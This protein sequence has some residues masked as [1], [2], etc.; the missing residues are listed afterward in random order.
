MKLS[1]AIILIFFS[2]YSFS[3]VGV[4]TTDPKS[5]LHIEAS[6]ITTPN[7]TDGILI[8]RIDNFPVT[9]PT[10]DQNGMLVFLNTATVPSSPFGV[11]PI[12]FYYWS[13]P[14]ATWV[15]MTNNSNWSLT[16]NSGTIDGTHYLGTN[17]DVPLNFK[18]NSQKAGRIYARQTFFGYLS[19]NVNTGNDNT[20][21]GDEALRDNTTG[22]Q[23]TV[24]GSQAMRFNTIGKENT[25]VGRQ[26]LR[27]NTEGDENTAVGRHALIS[28]TLGDQNT[29]IGKN[30]MVSNTQG[31]ENTALGR[32]AL[33]SN[34]LGNENTAVGRNA[35][36]SSTI[37]DQN[38]AVGKNALI[39]NTDGDQNTAIGRHALNDNTTGFNNSAVGSNALPHN[40][41][42]KEN[43]AIGK[44]ALRDNNIG[45]KNTAIGTES[46]INNESGNQ[47]VGVGFAAMFVNVTGNENVAIGYD[48]LRDN[49]SGSNNTA[50]GKNALNSN[51]TGIRNTAIGYNSD[52]VSSGLENATAI[53]YDAIVNA[54]NKVR[55]GNTAVTVVE[56]QVALTTTSDSR[57]KDDINDIPLGL[58]FIN[59][60]RPV[61]YTRKNN[62]SKQK[63]WGIIAQE[64]K[65]A[66]DELNYENA[67]I[68]SEDNSENHYLSVRYTDLIS[69]II[70]AIQELSLKEKEIE[71]LKNKI[72]SQDV[73][74]KSLLERIEKLEK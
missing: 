20:A 56:A 23:N 54:S 58:N 40:T 35:L 45:E 26:A 55:I 60:L 46:L 5:M 30:A 37:G 53:G 43:T 68:V 74:L 22:E 18:V 49:I 4:G 12:G 31:N 10:I 24:I 15:G 71:A 72:E 66:I 2:C 13:N 14:L 25:A 3:Q 50:I 44:D 42:G 70:K 61:E 41:T 36:A 33:T 21:I 47:N 64:L 6:N 73:L 27:N 17:D 19:G 32:H 62:D 34:T 63:E 28:N 52:V 65:A 1:I 59:S 67:G 8:P 57:F 7:N 39:S 38:T 29:A 51:T 69:P 48:A 11:N 16:G 9:N